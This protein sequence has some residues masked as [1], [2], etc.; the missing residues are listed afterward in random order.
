MRVAIRALEGNI[1]FDGRG[2]NAPPSSWTSAEDDLVAVAQ[3]ERPDS[4]DAYDHLLCVLPPSRPGA[5]LEA[6]RAE[7]ALPKPGQ[8]ATMALGPMPI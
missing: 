2:Q 1:A 4:L 3:R 6:A 8:C 5:P 7:I